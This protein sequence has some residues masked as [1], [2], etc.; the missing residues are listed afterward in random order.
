[1]AQ[2]PTQDLTHL[3]D[4]VQGFDI[5]VQVSKYGNAD[6]VLEGVFTGFMCRIINQTE[7]YL[8][9]NQRVPRMLD[10]E[11]IVAWSLEQ[12]MVTDKPVSH[13]FGEKFAA[14]YAKGRGN[15]STLNYVPR[16]VRFKVVMST[17][18]NNHLPAD[19]TAGSEEI[20]RSLEGSG[21]KLINMNISLEYCRIDTGSYGVVAGKRM[22]ASSWQGTAQS[23]G[24]AV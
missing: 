24:V 4:P 3:A 20:F 11:I 15:G 10:G 18:V 2:E 23:L 12:A 1:M 6:T 5:K 16:Q 21:G 9:L 19:T 7:A 14:A 17:A 13:T 8:A 22:A